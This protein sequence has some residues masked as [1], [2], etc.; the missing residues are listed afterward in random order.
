[1]RRLNI[2][3][4]TAEERK[5]CYAQ[6]SQIRE[7][8]GSIGHLRGD[9]GSS[10]NEFYTT[11]NDHNVRLKT[12][13]FK[14]E[15]DELINELRFE[16]NGLLSSRDSIKL[17]GNALVESRF[18]G[19][20]TTEYGFRMDTENYSFLF[21]CNPTKGDYNFYCYCYVKDKLDEHIKKAI[22]EKTFMKNKDKER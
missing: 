3:A 13:D 17:F 14:A 5:Y 9:F 4:L 1:M 12:E 10:G 16:N 21:R 22:D 15:F 2:R 11:W 18:K 6:S 8:T 19:S 7:I 20:Y